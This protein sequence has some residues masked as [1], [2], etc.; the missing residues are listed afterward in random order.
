MEKTR[1]SR[2]AN[3]NLSPSTETTRKKE[4]PTER[5]SVGGQWRPVVG[6]KGTGLVPVLAV[7]LQESC[8]G[9]AAFRGA[10]K[11]PLDQVVEQPVYPSATRCEGHS[12][13][14]MHAQAFWSQRSWVAMCPTLLQK[15]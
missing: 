5:C 15:R 12:Q 8:L 9:R 10:A 3:Q 14:E 6:L 7:H 13:G 1:G 4:P 11:G 2:R